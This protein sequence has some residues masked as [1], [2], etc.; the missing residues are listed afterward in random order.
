MVDAYVKA[1]ESA[2]HKYDPDK[3]YLR[4]D[5]VHVREDDVTL[6]RSRTYIRVW[7]YMMEEWT[8]KASY[9]IAPWYTPIY[10]YGIIDN[11]GD[12]YFHDDL[13]D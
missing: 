8:S 1:N 4:L 11:K 5:T 6:D 10:D 13:P 9:L 7:L 3:T 12:R 2:A